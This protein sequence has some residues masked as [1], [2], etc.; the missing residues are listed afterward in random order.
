M[1]KTVMIPQPPSSAGGLWASSSTAKELYIADALRGLMVVGRGGGG[2]ADLI[3]GRGDG[4]HS[5][6]NYNFFLLLL[7]GFYATI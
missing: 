6:P 5:D 4:T 3:A 2:G 1:V 7:L